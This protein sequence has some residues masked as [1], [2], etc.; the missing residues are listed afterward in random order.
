MPLPTYKM[1]YNMEIYIRK[2]TT[3]Q[4]SEQQLKSFVSRR[5]YFVKQNI[6]FDKQI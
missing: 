3:R 1:V 4:E 6:K 2:A 5:C